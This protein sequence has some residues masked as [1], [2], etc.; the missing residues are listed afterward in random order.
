MAKLSLFAAEA[1]NTTS[2]VVKVIDLR[3][4]VPD[5]GYVIIQLRGTFSTA[6]VKPQG[7][8]DN[9]N[10]TN[11]TKDKDD[12]TSVDVVYTAAAFFGL[13]IKNGMWLR[14][15]ITSGTSESITA[16]ILGDVEAA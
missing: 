13:Q 8:L 2:N 4:D 14:L 7:S 12:G 1:T 3:S 10:F 15:E 6:I 11:I 16:D 9:T 5:S